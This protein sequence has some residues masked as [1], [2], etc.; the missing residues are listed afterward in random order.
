MSDLTD[1]Q[2]RVDDLMSTFNEQSQLN[3]CGKSPTG[4]AC[5]GCVQICNRKVMYDEAHDMNYQG[6]PEYIIEE[7]I[8]RDIY[9]KHKITKEQWVDWLARHDLLEKANGLT[10]SDN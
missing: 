6:D 8:P 9:R 2:K 7:A 1:E 5:L 3:W 10:R 4:C